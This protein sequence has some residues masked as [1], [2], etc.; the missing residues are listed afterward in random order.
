MKLVPG[1]TYDLF[2]WYMKGSILCG[3]AHCSEGY[4]QDEY[5]QDKMD[6]L[7]SDIIAKKDERYRNAH[8]H[9]KCMRC[10]QAIEERPVARDSDETLYSRTGAR[11]QLRNMDRFF[12]HN[13]CRQKAQLHLLGTI[14]QIA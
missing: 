1:K 13:H 5:I 11:F 2:S 7:S 6:G 3:D 8:L 14:R 9:K 4:R 10:F 12:A